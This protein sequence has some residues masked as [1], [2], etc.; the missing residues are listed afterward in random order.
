MKKL[1]MK[2]LQTC[3]EQLQLAC[4]SFRMSTLGWTIFLVRLSKFSKFE[5]QK[6]LSLSCIKKLSMK[7]FLISCNQLLL[8]FTTYAPSGI[9]VLCNH[10][11]GS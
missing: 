9:G 6:Y 11:A 8:T 10:K 3:F 7:H 1:S 2:I 5:I 4:Y